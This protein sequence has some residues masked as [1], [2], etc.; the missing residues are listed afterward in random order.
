MGRSHSC[1]AFHCRQEIARPE[2]GLYPISAPHRDGKKSCRPI[3]ERAVPLERAHEMP[4]FHDSTNQDAGDGTELLTRQ[5]YGEWNGGEDDWHDIPEH[6]LVGKICWIVRKSL[7]SIKHGP[8]PGG[9]GDTCKPLPVR[10]IAFIFLAA[11]IAAIGAA[12]L[13][14]IRANMLHHPPHQQ[15]E[16][17]GDVEQGHAFANGEKFRP[18]P[19]KPDPNRFA[20]TD[21]TRDSPHQPHRCGLSEWEAWGPCSERC[22]WGQRA[23]TRSREPWALDK[24]EC[25]T[26]KTDELKVCHLRDCTEAEIE[27][28]QPG[29]D[30]DEQLPRDHIEADRKRADD[31]DEDAKNMRQ[32]EEDDEARRNAEPLDEQ[33]DDAAAAAEV[34]EE[35]RAA[36]AADEEGETGKD[37]Y[38]DVTD[39]D[40]WGPC[41]ERCGWGQRAR[42]R[43]YGPAAGGGAGCKPTQLSQLKPCRRRECT[44]A[45]E[46]AVDTSEVTSSPTFSPAADGTVPHWT[47]NK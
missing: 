33:N 43:E 8:P 9:L 40:S 19:G 23:R 6:D 26:V 28:E 45:E 22:G 34:D 39:W 15:D 4:L 18:R 42:E 17:A 44:D 11:A 10:I 35:E 47:K 20:I 27:N 32:A 41:T 25:R 16:P 1:D 21:R 3:H 12:A 38:C 31:E 36:K 2:E 29:H 13:I 14:H 37:A 46:S 7:R 5:T 24:A 30:G